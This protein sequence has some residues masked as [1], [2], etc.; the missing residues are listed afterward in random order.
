MNRLNVLSPFGLP[1]PLPAVG[2]WGCA[3]AFF[4]MLTHL[5]MPVWLAAAWA[6]LIP[7]W[8]AMQSHGWMK[9]VLVLVGF[10]LSF[11]LMGKATLVPPWAW[12]L[13]LGLLLAI[14]P[15]RAWRDAPLFPTEQGSL[16]G[17]AARLA[18]APDAR[19][20]DA[21]C[22]LG[23]SLRELNTE[24][25]RSL[26]SGVEKSWPLA[27]FARM[28][29]PFAR[30]RAGDMWAQ[31]W[32]EQDVVYLFQRP[33]TMERAWH[34]ARSEMRAGAWL[35]SLEFAVP[36]LNATHCLQVSGRRPVWAYQV[37]VKP[38]GS[39]TLQDNR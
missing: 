13:P 4:M 25:P 1:W 3:W 22:G 26:L 28:L 8:V 9:R 15:M 17:L 37:P 36:R 39:N 23:H 38:D 11:L 35:V 27:M 21:G 2:A 12:L 7:G 29:C 6:L 19:I 24:W 16:R 20:L 14:Y 33:E 34:K 5:R 32:R 31:D 10:P 30:V 18:I